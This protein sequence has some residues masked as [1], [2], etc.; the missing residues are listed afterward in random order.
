MWKEST[1]TIVSTQQCLCRPSDLKLGDIIF[2]SYPYIWLFISQHIGYMFCPSN[3]SLSLQAK[4]F[5]SIFV[6]ILKVCILL[7]FNFLQFFTK[8]QVVGLLWNFASM[9]MFVWLIPLTIFQ[10]RS[11]LFYRIFVH[12]PKVWILSGFLFSSNCLKITGYWTKVNK[13]YILNQNGM[14]Y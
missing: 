5:Y 6:H 9:H 10:A 14:N 2:Y 4:S 13:I 3:S 11:V 12:I 8:L 1:G 7:G